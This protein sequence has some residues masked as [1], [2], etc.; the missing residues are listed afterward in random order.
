[1]VASTAT[2]WVTRDVA[3]VALGATNGVQL[4]VPRSTS[5]REFHCVVT[6]ADSMKSR[7]GGLTRPSWM[8]ASAHHVTASAEASAHH[9]ANRHHTRLGRWQ[10]HQSTAG[11]HAARLAAAFTAPMSASATPARAARTRSERRGSGPSASITG[12][13]THGASIIAQVSEEIDPTVVSTRGHSANATAPTSREVRVPT[14]SASAT[15]T[16][17]QHPTVSSSAHHN[18]WVTQPGTP[19]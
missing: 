10:A 17:P 8:S 3:A 7:N 12:S 15:R 13:S 4:D 19:S 18:R 9:P 2:G 1:M 16:I 6:P 14:P 11:R 5:I